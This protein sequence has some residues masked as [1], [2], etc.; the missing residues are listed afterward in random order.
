MIWSNTPGEKADS[1]KA[2]VESKNGCAENA[3]SEGRVV[4][5]ETKVMVKWGPI[6]HQSYLNSILRKLGRH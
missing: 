1:I 4:N 3:L 6:G 5:K 2:C